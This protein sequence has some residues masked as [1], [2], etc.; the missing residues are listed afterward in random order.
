MDRRRGAFSSVV[1]WWLFCVVLNANNDVA[2]GQ[3]GICD[4]KGCKCVE[5]FGGWKV[6]NCSFTMDQDLIFESDSIHKELLE[7][8]IVGGNSLVF[9]E[10]SFNA[11]QGLSILYI[12]SANNIIVKTHAFFN[13]S[14]ASLRFDVE[15]CDKLLVGSEAFINSNSTVITDFNKVEYCM[16]QSAAFSKLV[17]ATF[18]NISKLDLVERSFEI[19]KKDGIVRHGPA[20]KITFNNV[21]I[22]TIPSRTFFS[23]LAEIS[24][25]NSEINEIHS[26][27]FS[28]TQIT[29][30][31]MQN[32]T[33]NTIKSEACPSISLIENFKISKCNISRLES[34]AVLCAISKLSILNSRIQTIETGAIN[35]TSAIINLVGNEIVEFKSSALGFNS[36]WNKILVEQNMIKHLGA[37]SIYIYGETTSQENPQFSFIN[38]DIFNLD[39]NS[40]SFVAN[41][42]DISVVFEENYFNV[43]CNCFLDT[44]L[45]KLLKT[46]KTVDN[47]MNSSFCTVDDLLARCYELKTGLINM[48][49][50]TELV[51]APGNTINCEPYKGEEK[52]VNITN[53]VFLDAPQA[54]HSRL[55]LF[56]TVAG[57]VIIAIVATFIFL[58]IVGGRW[59]K[60]N[61]YLRNMHYSPNE[62]SNDEENTIVTIDQE[63]EEP[64]LELPE[65]LTL[66]Y[67]EYLKKRLDDPETHQETTEMIEKLY[68]MFVIEDNYENNN[69]QD[70][71]AHLYEEL[72]NMQAQP[73]DRKSTDNIQNGPLS[74]LRMMEERFN[75]QFIDTEEDRSKSSPFL[76]D[77]SEPSDAAVHLYSELKQ[78][79]MQNEKNEKKD[80]LKSRGSGSMAARPLPNK[81]D[82]LYNRAGPSSVD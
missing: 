44:W 10:K 17:N 81:P 54:D 64:K 5:R 80:S 37:D 47:V 13:S 20:T 50:F 16:V 76:N 31:Y 29:M 70:E 52:I 34:R 59:V 38:N 62:T 26:D 1:F 8:F 6:V 74:I 72:A 58:L 60:R 23:P 32:S 48:M 68:E 22:S 42:D 12:G 82:D 15:N 33:I 65:E 75:L 7:I 73:A 45:S 56:L 9:Q 78:N 19:T 40:L 77:Y 3:S 61:W 63:S 21:R 14:S 39:V 27:A 11:L 69:K 57:L 71:E 36:W 43:K 28:A 25:L 30:I 24:I 79:Q 18:Q 35:T 53:P 55:V 4:M 41:L 51:C 67:L 46:N 66:E 49:N 2:D